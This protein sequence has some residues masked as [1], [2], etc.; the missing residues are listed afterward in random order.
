[1]NTACGR[2]FLS[3]LRLNQKLYASV[4]AGSR[5]F[6]GSPEQKKGRKVVLQ[7]VARNVKPFGKVVVE[8]PCDVEI[9]PTDFD[10]YPDM[11]ALLVR[12]VI[13]EDSATETQLSNLL[14]VEVNERDVWEVKGEKLIP[15]NAKCLIE[16]PVRYSK[17]NPTSLFILII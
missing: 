2:F 7:E 3:Y 6:G 10:R 4:P 15:A 17:Q 16:S 13:D 9:R 5:C 12:V 1:M 14:S 11:N 8:V